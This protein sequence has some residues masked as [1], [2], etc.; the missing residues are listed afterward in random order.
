MMIDTNII[1]YS[2]RPEHA[3]LQ[4]WLLEQM[5]CCSVISRVETLGYHR[6]TTAAQRSLEGVLSCMEVIYPSPVTFERAIQ[7]RQQRRISLGDALIAATALEHRL[8]L[9]T[10]NLSDFQWI[11]G[12]TIVNPMER[13]INA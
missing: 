9:A 6:L 4:S 2:L 8:V 10:T 12:L 13:S 3:Q 5:P 1:I 11:Q 7:L